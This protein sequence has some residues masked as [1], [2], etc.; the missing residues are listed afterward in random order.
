ML[1]GRLYVA[2]FATPS[3]FLSF[4]GA[5][6]VRCAQPPCGSRSE[7]PTAVPCCCRSACMHCP[8]PNPHPQPQ[9]PSAHAAAAQFARDVM[10]RARDVIRRARSGGARRTCRRSGRATP[11]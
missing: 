2:G 6:V 7:Q 11:S 10:R 1:D 8:L 4:D 9:F 5:K 3:T